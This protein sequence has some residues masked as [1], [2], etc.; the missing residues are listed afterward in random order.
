MSGFFFCGMTLDV[1]ANLS[2]SSMNENSDVDQM[3]KSSASRLKFVIRIA[4]CPTYSAAKSRDPVA[5]IE[6]SIRPLNP[7]IL[8]VLCL[9]IGKLVPPTGPAPSGDSFTRPY[10]TYSRSKSLNKAS[11]YAGNRLGQFGQQRV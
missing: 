3:I 10:V 7:S 6:F 11:A 1:D 5:S 2:E 8:A 9:S 4:T